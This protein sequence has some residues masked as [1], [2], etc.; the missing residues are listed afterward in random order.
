MPDNLPIILLPG[1]GLDE[2][3]YA[4]QTIAISSVTV[5][6][7]LKPTY[8]ESLPHYA[9]R[10]AEIVDPKGPCY[11]GG[12]S[13]GGMIAL[14]MSRHLDCRGVFL[15]SSI[16]SRDELPY[17]A[18]FLAPW[19]WV[20]PPRA[21]LIASAAGTSIL[22]TVGRFLPARWRLFCIHLSKTRA[23]IL[24]WA[25]RAAVKWKPTEPYAAPVYHLH[26]DHDPIFPHHYTQVTQLVP[27]GGH[28]LPLT[29]PFVVNEFL[30]RGMEQSGTRADTLAT[31]VR[32]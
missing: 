22:W 19:A 29:H 15:I 5:P 8:F 9:K 25:C 17:W 30:R 18:R 12:V 23:T 4:A 28:L 3:L 14:E 10:M 11:V 2:R 24:P 26:G 21:D 27:R 6:D 32:V 31:E 7:W 16:R 1:I 13:L 20:L